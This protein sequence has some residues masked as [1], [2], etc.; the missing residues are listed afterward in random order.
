MALDAA[1]LLLA[2]QLGEALLRA[3]ATLAVAES[4]TGGG[5]G[6]LVTAI[7]GS[8]NW[9][10]RGFVT[11]SNAAKEEMLGVP[12]DTLSRHGAVSEET[13]AAMATG[14]LERSHAD[15]SVSVTGVAGPDGG[16]DDKPVGTVCFGWSAR[17]GETRTARIVFDGDRAEVRQRSILMAVQGVIDRVDR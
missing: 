16:S 5:I 7:P 13:A 12:A 15:F 6:Y 14:A 9:F 1:A 17:G 10:D 11:Y 2:E 8:S 4:C 3:R